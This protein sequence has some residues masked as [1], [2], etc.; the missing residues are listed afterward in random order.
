MLVLKMKKGYF[1][2]SSLAIVFL[3]L[4]FISDKTAIAERTALE[5]ISDEFVCPQEL[6]PYVEFWK[7]VFARYNKY[8]ILFHHRDYPDVIYS[9]LDF[10]DFKDLDE[11]TIRRQ[12]DAI[13]KNEVDRIKKDLLY[14]HQGNLPQTSRQKRI[15]QLF[16]R[17]RKPNKYQIA[18]DE[19]R[20]QVGMK[21]RFAESV[22][23]AGK[24]L[25]AIERIFAEE[26]LPLELARI[27]FVESSFNYNA[28][29]SVGASGIWQFMRSTG[30]NY[31]RI[32]NYVD[33][34][35][36]PIASS[37]AAARYLKAAY[38]TLGSWPLAVTSYNHGVTGIARASNQ[39]G[40]KRLFDL[41]QN[42][43]SESF[44]F[45]SKNFFVS[46][47][48]ALDVSRSHRSYFP[49]LVV[50]DPVRFDEVRLAKALS[51]NSA[52]SY[53]GL[54]VE[55]F[56]FLNPSLLAP[57]RNGR[58]P[59]P[60]GVSVKMGPG[61][62]K[63][64]LAAFGGELLSLSGEVVIAMQSSSPRDSV[65]DRTVARASTFEK[66]QVRSML[67]A[68]ISSSSEDKRK[69]NSIYQVSSGD[70]LYSIAKNHG[71]SLDQVRSLNPKLS[72]FIKPGDKIVLK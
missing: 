70:T 64:A 2:F 3:T 59:I 30:K 21:E 14:L 16:A 54:P 45:A 43:Q 38:R 29:S 33:E 67:K 63:V 18:A 46:F 53:S 49:G 4:L 17:I 37:R 56:D 40:S 31:M 57:I 65:N 5:K 9:V 69:A 50:S 44:G 62:G 6:A 24:Y 28:V 35:R 60:A 47:L 71:L 32:D 26:G 72:T 36:D 55:S 48:A 20:S 15:A 1:L 61:H 8:Q 34:R 58:A 7:L 41:I 66:S 25:P 19:I 68:P 13:S 12:Q 22:A 10:S 27:P 52:L 23:D 11:A 42:Y 39:V 51:Y